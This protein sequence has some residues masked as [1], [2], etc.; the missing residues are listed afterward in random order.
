MLQQY[1]AATV[2]IGSDKHN[3]SACNQ[4]LREGA[5]GTMTA[6]PMVFRGPMRGQMSSRGGPSKFGRKNSRNF[7]ED[8]FFFL[9]KTVEILLKTFFFWRS[10][11]FGR[12]PIQFEGVH[13]IIFELERGPIQFEGAHHIIL[14]FEWRPIQFEGANPC[15]SYSRA[16]VR[17]SAPLRAMDNVQDWTNSPQHGVRVIW[18]C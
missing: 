16:H 9:R 3:F 5:G 18:F 7:G 12:G 15:L 2:C 14:E 10:L 13:H 6:G 4:G 17:L 1:H 8:L 11:D